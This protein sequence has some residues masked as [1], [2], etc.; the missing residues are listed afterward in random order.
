MNWMSFFLTTVIIITILFFEWPKTRKKSKKDKSVFIVLL[1][2][3]WVLSIF[4]LPQISGPIDW[5]ETL[6]RPLG[7]F[8]D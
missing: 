7:Q 8:I 5:L 1:A 6:F 4:E 2:A 3:G